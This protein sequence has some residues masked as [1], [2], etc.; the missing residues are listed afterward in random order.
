MIRIEVV[1]ILIAS[2]SGNL[3][4]PAGVPVLNYWE[5]SQGG[6]V[7]L[8]SSI[9]ADINDDGLNDIIVSFRDSAHK[10][11]REVYLNN[12]CRWIR[13]SGGLDKLNYCKAALRSL[14]AKHSCTIQIFWVLLTLALTV[15]TV[16]QAAAYLQ[17]TNDVVEALIREKKL[18]SIEFA[19]ERRIHRVHLDEF[20]LKE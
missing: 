10:E 16:D 4:P 1:L 12:G 2:V 3:F 9:V 14:S 8:P 6:Y 13:T 11:Y 20:F 19:D 7:S 5:P 17:T 18:K 15:F